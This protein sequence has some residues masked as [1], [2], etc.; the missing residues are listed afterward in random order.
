M[1]Y[2]Q[3]HHQAKIRGGYERAIGREKIKKKKDLLVLQE[4]KV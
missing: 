3:S 4:N 1:H 2:Q